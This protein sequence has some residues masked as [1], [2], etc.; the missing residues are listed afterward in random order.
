[1][2][3]SSINKEDKEAID[4]LV[5]EIVKAIKGKSVNCDRTYKTVIKQ[6]TKKGYVI[7]DESGNERTV[8]CCIPGLELKVMQ[9]V[10]VKEP[11]GRLNDLHICGV[12]GK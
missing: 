11:M 2:Y 7:L 10:W 12:I 8:Q 1:M 9:S 5:K 6:I 4:I 3:Q